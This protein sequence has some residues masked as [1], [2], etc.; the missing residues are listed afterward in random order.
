MCDGKWKVLVMN[1]VGIISKKIY[2]KREGKEKGEM[3][4]EINE[5]DR[6]GVKDLVM[7]EDLK[8]VDEL[9]EKIRKRLKEKIIYK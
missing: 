9:V 3:E 8:S 1:D 5:R 2:E 7:I 6:V 4:R